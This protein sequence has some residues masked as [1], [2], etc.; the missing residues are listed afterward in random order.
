MS[1]AINAETFSPYVG[2]PA[3][4]ANGQALTLVAVDLHRSPRPDAAP[5]TS[6][7]LLLRGAAAPI[8][9]EGLHRLAFEDAAT[10]IDLT[11]GNRTFWDWRCSFSTRKG[12][13][14]EMARVVGE[15][16]YD[17]G[18]TAIRNRLAASAGLEGRA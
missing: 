8:V 2:R 10:S 6:F 7:S 14:A 18:F 15:D 3:S 11:D 4:L 9:S 16:I 12:E 17:A 13:E 1:D 5:G